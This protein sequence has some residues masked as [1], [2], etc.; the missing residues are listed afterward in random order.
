MVRANILKD[1]LELEWNEV[2]MT[3]NTVTIKL[4][5]SVTILLKDKFKA[6]RM[7]KRDP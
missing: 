3:L 7:L 1:I 6:R 5:T 2:K 4:P